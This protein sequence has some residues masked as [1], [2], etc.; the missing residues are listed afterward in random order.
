MEEEPKAPKV[1]ANRTIEQIIRH[2]VG[3][4]VKITPQ[5]YMVVRVV[6]RRLGG[7]WEKL[8]SGDLVHIELLKQII[9][10]W[11]KLPHPDEKDELV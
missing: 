9:G 10:G 6:F 5:D 8:V 1:F 7:Q 11:G 2:M 3:E 4:T